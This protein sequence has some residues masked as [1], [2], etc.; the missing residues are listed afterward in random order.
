MEA[1]IEP[2]VRDF[3]AWLAK[4]P[5]LHAEVIEN[6]RTSCPRLP[7]WEECTDQKFVARKGPV[8]EVTPRGHAF[9]AGARL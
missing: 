1:T 2:L 8:V 7:V 4:E 9:L 5:R 6:W 3:L